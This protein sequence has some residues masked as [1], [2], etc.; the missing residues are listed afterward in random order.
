MPV[1]VLFAGVDTAGKGETVNT[2]SEWMDPRWLVARAYGS[3]SDEERERPAFWRYWRDLPAKGRIGLF[4]S[5]WYSEPVLDRVHRATSRKEFDG[6][7]EEIVDLRKSAHRRRRRDREILDASQPR[8]AEEAAS[9]VRE[10]SGQALA[11]HEGAVEELARIRPVHR[12][13][14]TG[15]PTHEQRPGALVHRR[16]PRRTVSD[17]DGGHRAPRR[18]SRGAGQTGQ[19]VVEPRCGRREIRRARAGSRSARACG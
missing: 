4:L 13:R 7:L 2:L 15:D 12:G 11:R 6:Q 18:D 19:A 17:P 10:G 16:R 5:A 14:R 1:I 3:R 9:V 8:R